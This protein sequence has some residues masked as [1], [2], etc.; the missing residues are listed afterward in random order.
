MYDTHPPPEKCL[1]LAEDSRDDEL[2]FKR[3][4][5]R[6]GVQNPLKVVRDGSEVIAYLKGEGIYSNR[7]L[8]PKPTALFLDLIM[9]PVGGL[10]VLEWL[11]TQSDFSDMLTVVLSGF[12]QSQM[13]RE[14]YARGTDTF[15]FK[16]LLLPDLES[17]I[18]HF[19]G[20]WTIGEEDDIP[21][22]FKNLPTEV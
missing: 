18:Q 11:Q 3:T 12:N 17:L 16:P 1:L 20:H 21:L 22:I 5:Q 6:A 8:C 14:A 15:L 10:E 7:K 4:F 19:P 13:L 9:H 2:W